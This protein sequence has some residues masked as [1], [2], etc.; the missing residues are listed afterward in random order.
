MRQPFLCAGL[1]Y[2]PAFFMLRPFLCAGLFYAPAFFM[3][4]SFLCSDLFFMRRGG[5]F[6]LLSVCVGALDI[7]VLSTILYLPCKQTLGCIFLF[8][9]QTKNWGHT[10]TILSRFSLSSFRF[11]TYLP[12]QTVMMFK[13][14]TV[15]RTYVCSVHTY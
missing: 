6:N 5:L 7:L 11:C 8:C 10:P 15:T 12:R 14:S 1:F 4:R 2:A 9:C 13:T 3:C